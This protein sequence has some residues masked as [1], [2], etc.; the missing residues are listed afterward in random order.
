MLHHKLQNETRPGGCKY[1]TMNTRDLNHSFMRGER[2]ETGL[3]FWFV[4]S[5]AA[6][7]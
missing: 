6:K 2:N 3:I 1:I 7:G 4:F 5:R